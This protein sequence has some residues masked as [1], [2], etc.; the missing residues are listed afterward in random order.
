MK[1]SVRKILTLAL[2]LALVCA[3]AVSGLAVTI[4]DGA[5]FHEYILV[6]YFLTLEEHRASASVTIDDTYGNIYM[7]NTG[8]IILR[9]SYYDADARSVTSGAKQTSRIFSTGASVTANTGS[10]P[11][12]YMTTATG[13]YNLTLEIAGTTYPYHPRDLSLTEADYR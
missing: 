6:D 10:N 11:D 5:M 12:S 8:S 4:G 1:K 3:L 7:N 13:S 9:Y 2:A